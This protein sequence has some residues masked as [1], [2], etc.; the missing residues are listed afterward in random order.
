MGK[1]K[2]LGKIYKTTDGI[3]NGREDIKKSRPVIVVDQ[4]DDGAVAIVKIHSQKGK[5][6]KMYIEKL[7]LKP[8]NHKA[9][10]EDSIVEKTIHLGRKSNGGYI[11]IFV[12]DL[13]DMDDGLTRSELHKV[14]KGVK[15]KKIKQ[16]RKHKKKMKK[17]HNHFK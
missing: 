8:A 3:F 11:P 9:L 2:D 1:K 10:N 14:K 6:G 7:V 17:W 15:G 5:G 13:V 12:S 16:K 4:R